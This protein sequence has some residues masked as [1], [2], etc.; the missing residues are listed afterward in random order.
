M[1]ESVTETKVK[2]EKAV[3]AD[4]KENESVAEQSVEADASVKGN[5]LRKFEMAK[6]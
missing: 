4:E 3:K 2:A 6:K 1:N 5:V